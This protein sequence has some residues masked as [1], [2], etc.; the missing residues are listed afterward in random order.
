MYIFGSVGAPWNAC[1][2]IYILYKLR[3]KTLQP[4]Q[5]LI[6]NIVSSSLSVEVQLYK[7]T[8]GL[9]TCKDVTWTDLFF[10]PLPQRLGERPKVNCHGGILLVEEPWDFSLKPRHCG[11]VSQVCPAAAPGLE[12]I[13]VFVELCGTT[14]H[15]TPTISPVNAWR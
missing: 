9:L 12:Y 7:I 14:R 13:C 11:Q 3:T 1:L 10:S 15:K 6:L 2:W 8:W 4:R 5:T